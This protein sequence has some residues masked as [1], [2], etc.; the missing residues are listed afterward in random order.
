MKKQMLTNIFSEI[1]DFLV[2]SASNIVSVAFKF[3]KNK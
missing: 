3:L 2:E 1:K